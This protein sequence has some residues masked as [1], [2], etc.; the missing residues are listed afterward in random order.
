MQ[1]AGQAPQNTY[2][3]L[4][5]ARAAE[6]QQWRQA[7]VSVLAGWGA[8]ANAMELAAFGVSELLSNVVKHVQDPE[9]HLRVLRLG[10]RV[11]IQVYDRAPRM[12][13]I[14]KP[15]WDS[16]SG[17]GLWLLREMAD[18]LG[19]E[20]APF[21]EGKTTWFSCRLARADEAAA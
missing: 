14:V 9:C 4:L 11:L 20:A 17:R 18:G 10:D 5:T 7:V 15:S 1:V 16:E 6:I 2:G 8:D 21:R 3:W 13:E 19:W 12:P